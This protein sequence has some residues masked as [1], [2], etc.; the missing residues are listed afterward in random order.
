MRIPTAKDK[1]HARA[2][3]TFLVGFGTTQRGYHV[4]NPEDGKIYIS[5]DVRF[6]ETQTYGLY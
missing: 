3:P 6:V 5:R 1:L 2:V 4:C